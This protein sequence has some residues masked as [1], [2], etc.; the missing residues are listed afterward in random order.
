MMGE[1][2]TRNHL[3]EIVKDD[4]NTMKGKYDIEPIA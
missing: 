4:I 3:L 1:P 2:K